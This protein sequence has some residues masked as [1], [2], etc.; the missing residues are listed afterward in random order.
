MKRYI[1]PILLALTL[2]AMPLSII[3]A[4]PSKDFRATTTSGVMIYQSNYGIT[5]YNT[6]ETAPG[7]IWPRNS[8]DQ[9]VFGGGLWL[10]GKLMIGDFE[11]ELVVI[12]F[13]PNSGMSW[14][15]P[16]SELVR[17][18]LGATEILSSTFSDSDL[19]LYE[20]G[21]ALRESQG[22]PLGVVVTQTL[23]GWASG[24][25]KDVITV[26][27]TVRNNHS[28][29][30]IREFILTNVL[31]MDI[32]K[33]E[34]VVRASFNDACVLIAEPKGLNIFKGYSKPELDGS[35]NGVIGIAIVNGPGAGVIYSAS[36]INLG[37]VQSEAYERYEFMS[38]GVLES[39]SEPDDI[40]SFFSTSP[41]D[42]NPGDSISSTLVLMFGAT[43]DAANDQRMIEIVE[44]LTTSTGIADDVRA[45]DS[46]TVFPNPAV[47]SQ[48]INIISTYTMHLVLLCCLLRIQQTR[49][50]CLRFLRGTTR[51]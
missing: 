22:Y 41:V 3:H 32:G 36:S 42:L 37:V 33:L 25:L 5:G 21:A 16:E 44:S 51:W 26:T 29:R 19:N 49:S 2:V 4:Q 46:F 20:G 27:S 35:T 6:G 47:S 50:M 13:N 15:K 7:V 31:D 43:N 11:R 8:S 10:G 1:V 48:H 38:T 12:S 23:R 18:T 28:T 39:T 9:Y 30:P 45:D 14:F 17:K 40:V 24:A 34:D